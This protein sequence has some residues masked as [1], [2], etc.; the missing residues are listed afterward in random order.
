MK[1]PTWLGATSGRRSITNVPADVTTTACLLAMSAA[2]N[3]VVN[4]AAGFGAAAGRAPRCWA[5]AN[6]ARIAAMEKRIAG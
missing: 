5:G 4:G 2:E 6:A 3:G 1:Y